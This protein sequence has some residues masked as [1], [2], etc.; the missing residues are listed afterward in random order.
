[1]DWK[2]LLETITK[3]APAPSFVFAV[4]S[5]LLL[6]DRVTDFFGI[7]PFRDAQR[8]WIVF[9]FL[10]S[11]LFFCVH[12]LLLCGRKVGG[13]FGYVKGTRQR[14][15]NLR[16]LN[17]NERAFLRRF[18]VT[19]GKPQHADMSNGIANGLEAK[20]IIYRAATMFRITQGIPYNVQPWAW[21]II[22]KDEAVLG[23][24][25]DYDRTLEDMDLEGPRRSR[26]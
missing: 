14:K 1:M 7:R 18:V 6:S 20:G 17:S 5:G 8:H 12:A 21:E 4:A 25:E 23:T 3:L 10:V 19:D 22:T 11:A 16:E 9:T 24:N 2:A 26:P 15:N 13:L